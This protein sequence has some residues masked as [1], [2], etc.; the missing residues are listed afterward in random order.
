MEE[1]YTIEILDNNIYKKDEINEILK[2]N[3]KI[4]K[5]LQQELDKYKAKEKELREMFEDETLHNLNKYYYG[6][7]YELDAHELRND[8][9]QILNDKVVE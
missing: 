6:D 8:I 5:Q 7:S 4:Y 2:I 9:L 1:N 3:Y